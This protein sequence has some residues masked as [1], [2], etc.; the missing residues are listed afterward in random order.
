MSYDIGPRIGIEGEK[1]FKDSLSAVVSNVKA[2]GAE[3]KAVTAAF[4]GNEHS[5]EALT[6]QSG[7]LERS[8]SATEEEIALL[9]KQYDSQK[10]VLEGLGEAL[11]QAAAEYGETS[12][13]ALKAQNAYNRQYRTLNELKTKMENASASLSGFQS[14]LAANERAAAGL[15]GE[16]ARTADATERLTREIAEQEEKLSKLGRGYSNAVLEYGKGSDEAKKF[17]REIGQ[18]SSE[19]KSNQQRL[20][21]ASTGAEALGDAMEDASGGV[22]KM[23]EGLSSVGVAI[24][25]LMSSA[26]QAALEGL[27]D[28]G[29]A[30]W[31]LDEA[32]EAYRAAQ[33]RLNTAFEA[34]GYSTETA[35]QAYTDL[36]AILGDTDTAVEAA[37]LLAQLAD[38][39]EDMAQWAEIAAGVAGTFG[40]ALPINSLIEA[41]N[42][43]AK[44]GEITGAL[45]DA[46]NWAAEEGEPYGVALKASTEA[47]AEWNKAVEA[48]AS[49][50]DSFSLALQS[51]ATE[52]ERNQLIMSTLTQTYSEAS[53]AFYE[54]NAAVVQARE[55]QALLDESLAGLGETI[56]TVKSGLQAE[57]LPAIAEAAQAFSGMLAGAEG[58]DTAFAGA[59][60]K[61][62]ATGT[63]KLP[64]ILEFGGT[65]LSTL[66]EGIAGALPEIAGFVGEALSEFTAGVLELLPDLADAAVELATALADGISDSLPELIPAA[67]DTVMQIAGTLTDPE[68]LEHMISSALELIV[69]LAEGLIKAL[70]ELAERAPEIIKNLVTA[71]VAEGPQIIA[72]AVE[73]VTALADGISD[74]L[75]ELIPAAVDTVMQI[76]GTLTDPENLEHMI[77]SA[78]ELIVSLAE[79][80]IKAL[81]ELAERAPEIIK[82]LV[83]ALVA[84]GPQIIAAALE[85]VVTLGGGL[86]AALPDLAAF[87]P[88]VIAAIAGGL[89]EGIGEI[90][91]VGGQIVEGLWEGIKDMGS[92]IKEKVTGFFGGIVDSVKGLLGIRSPSRV[93][94]GI[95]GNMAEGLEQGWSGAY[96]HTK[97][98]IT[99]GLQDVADEARKIGD[100]FEGVSYEPDVDYSELMLAAKDLEEFQRLAAQ[101]SAKIV[102]ESLDT[103][104][105]G[106]AGNEELLERWQSSVRQSMDS[107]QRTV[108]GVSYAPDVDY[109][110]LMLAAEDLEKFQQLAAQRSAKIVGENIDLAAQGFAGN[111]ELLEQ[112]RD[113]VQRTM[114]SIEK[115]AGGVSYEPDVD[116][117]EWMLAAK[118]LEEF[119]AG[120][121]DMGRAFME[122]LSNGIAEGA[123]T[124]YDTMREVTRNTGA[125]FR[126]ELDAVCGRIDSA[127]SELGTAPPAR[128]AGNAGASAASGTQRAEGPANMADAVSRALS[129]A[130]VYMSGRKVGKLLTTQQGNGTIARGGGL[131]PVG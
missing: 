54:N 129:G 89:I 44:T 124:L 11:E 12:K 3:M 66:G 116:C 25:N 28:L 91:E 83:T 86:I 55:S 75:P 43:T 29:S 78:L 65:L 21:D 45:A 24:G 77:S 56:S 9:N 42:E 74:S 72:A 6:A 104:A 23:G 117:S 128:T 93:F 58:A 8:I 13:E 88:K 5:M 95:G 82:N 40:D 7:V 34:A 122:E 84:E 52:S 103:T 118:D 59:I 18:L 81:P 16:E 49:A 14:A 109:S 57:F 60:Q 17:E 69:S 97:R 92:W 31:N 87:I 125:V 79:G 15:S 61:L 68:N 32:T 33:G 123:S 115:S 35:H 96:R 114:D 62:V 53:A 26:I 101:R 67:V 41:A 30:L 127:M 100:L 111:A 39:E 85:L 90:E 119:I 130:A 110:A 51:C 102:G 37:Q 22:S 121:P 10:K 131:V 126:E 20:K 19:L 4:S 50:E 27:R 112:W 94:A 99:G 48:A 73:L 63:E 98:R 120:G 106:F 80:L 113:S 38:S 105:Q 36:Y 2:L 71:L 1:A 46:L 47:N 70:P 108:D 64:E 107:I 76:A